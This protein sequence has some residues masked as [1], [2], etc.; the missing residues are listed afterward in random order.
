MR[1]PLVDPCE[2]PVLLCT[3]TFWADHGDLLHEVVPTLRVELL[4]STWLAPD[5]LERITIA[6]CS[7]DVQDGRMRAF[8]GSCLRAPRLAWLQLF[9]S[10]TDDPALARLQAA[11]VVMTNAAGANAPPIAQTVM[12]YLLAF[13][14]NLPE[15]F[16]DQRE[17]RWEPLPTRELAGL[18]LGVLG[19]GA[20]G[21]QVARYARGFEIDVIGVRRSPRG[22]EPCPVWPTER[23]PE[24]LEW[25]DAL[26]IAAPLT[27]ETRGLIDAEA[28]ALMHP[29]SWLINIGRGEIVDERALA[30]ALV[31]GHLAAAGLDVFAAEPLPA[32]SP[33]WALPNVIVTPHSAGL[34][35]PSHERSI[36]AFIDNLR[37]FVTGEALRNVVPP[38]SEV[39]GAH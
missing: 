13:A 1:L 15:K 7:P 24:L 11:G 12:M 33:L 17:R 28:L 19:L 5:A 6:F 9:F 8:L 29:G 38:A 34:S 3:D 22:D 10:G 23:L 14:G 20:I 27:E 16:G 4:G 25:A 39:R 2:P 18:R 21:A 30:S 35:S 32:A 36:G 37:R 31:R 26:V